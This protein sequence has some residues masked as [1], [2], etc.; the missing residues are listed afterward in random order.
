MRYLWIALGSA[1]V[2]YLLG[3]GL[4]LG[5]M[6][7]PPESFAS[8]VARIPRRVMAAVPFRPMWLFARKGSLNVRDPA[9]DFVLQTLDHPEAVRLSSFRGRSPVVLIFGSYT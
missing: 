4:I 9:P 8:A 6:F 7:Q 5:L 2:V 1:V 3:A